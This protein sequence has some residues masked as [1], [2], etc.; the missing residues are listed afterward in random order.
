MTK[1]LDA[2]NGW[3]NH[4]TWMSGHSLDEARF[5]RAVYNILNENDKNSI[6][7]D[8]IRNYVTCQF[9][10]KLEKEY[11]ALMAKEA[12]KKFEIISEF[13]DANNL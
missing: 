12:A 10:G 13:C 9:T 5:Y 4:R 11:L 8:D 3:L 1:K 2:L 6:S 7:P